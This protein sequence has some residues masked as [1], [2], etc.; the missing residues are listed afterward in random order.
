M[1][2]IAS[3]IILG[4]LAQYTAWKVKVPAILPLI[5]IGLLVGPLSVYWN[6]GE[7]WMKPIFDAASNEGLFPGQSLFYFVSLSIGIILFEGGLTLKLSEIREVGP[8]I[9]K[10]ISLGSIVTFVLAGVA[11]HYIIHIRRIELPPFQ[12]PYTS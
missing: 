9:V 4:I 5:L 3:I 12:E 8:S 2:Q 1:A 11:A 6:E 7:V 10:L